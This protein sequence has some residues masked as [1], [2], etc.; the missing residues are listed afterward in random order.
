MTKNESEIP[1][2]GDQHQGHAKT[3]LAMTS[4]A[5]IGVVYGDIGTSPLYAYREAMVAAGGHRGGVDPEHILGVLSVITWALIIVVTIKYVIILLRADNDGEGGTFSLLALVQRAMGRP[6]P[7]VLALGMLGAGLFYGDAAVTPAISV[8]SAIE[9]LKL[10]T[11]AVEPFLV[12]IAVIIIVVL[13]VFQSK[14]TASVAKFFGPIMM[15]WF[16][17]LAAGGVMNLIQAPMVLQAL[18]PIRAAELVTSNGALGF[19]ILG[20]AFLAVTG[21]EALYADLG[22]F[23]RMPIRISW[24]A[25]VM[26]SLLLNYYGQG[27]LLMTHPEAI[28][29]PF[30]RLYPEWAVLPM[31]VLA[32]MATVIASQAVI[33]GAYS[34]TQQGVQLRLIPRLRIRQTSETQQGQIYMP[35]VNFWLMLGVLMLIVIFG[36]SSALAAA[37]GISV[38]GEMCITSILVMVVANRLWKMPLILSIAMMLPF[39]ALDLTFF[40]ANSM[41]IFSGG[42]V[43]LAI[44]AGMII[45]MWTW[46]RGAAIILKLERE[47]DVPLDMI[48][49]QMDS[50]SISTVPGTAIYLTGTP[51]MVPAAMLHSLKHFKALHEHIV[52]L[53]IVTEDVPR[54]PNESRVNMEELNERFRKVELRFG[55]AEEPDV[56]KALL[57]CRKLGWKFDIMAT[58]F[59]LSQRSLKLSGQR[60]MPAWQSLF[61]FYLARNATRSSDYFR[62]PASRV[63]ELGT[64][65]NV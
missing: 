21:A 53:T 65:V 8:L 26:P 52:I 11:P 55:Y 22:H 13:F 2:Q 27:A 4:L 45:L 37:Y 14:G 34:L 58:S 6:T 60:R 15:V 10:V 49:R 41:K 31:I 39:L 30:F 19:T 63:V 24:L 50:K 43:S 46:R 20:A 25:V 59:I 51:D 44:A 42:Y 56:P 32:G 7:I 12:P 62:I 23:G 57:Q 18:N 28:E 33:S 9:G 61:F 38:T 17:L 40:G 64:L 54:V 29:N 16:T 5:A 36:S 35:E 47:N 1:E 3:G 48:F